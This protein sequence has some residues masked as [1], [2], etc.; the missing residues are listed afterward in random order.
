MKKKKVKKKSKH[1]LLFFSKEVFTEEAICEL[2]KI[3]ETEQKI[4]TNNLIYET[5]DKKKYIKDHL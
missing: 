3:I 2:S 5:S 4:N 1:F